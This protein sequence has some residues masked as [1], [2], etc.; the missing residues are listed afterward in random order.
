MSIGASMVNVLVALAQLSVVP[1]ARDEPAPAIEAGC[2]AE[3]LKL[4]V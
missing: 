3:L 4:P 2:T 1:P